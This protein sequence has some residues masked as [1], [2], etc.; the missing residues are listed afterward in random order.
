[1][2]YHIALAALVI[3]ASV[4]FVARIPVLRHVRILRLVNDLEGQVDERAYGVVEFM[5]RQTITRRS[6]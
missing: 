4:A 3:V 6:K 1:M 5:R 2:N